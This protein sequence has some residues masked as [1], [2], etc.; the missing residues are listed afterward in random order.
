MLLEYHRANR[1]TELSPLCNSIIRQT[2]L[3]PYM[4]EQ[5]CL[6]EDKLLLNCFKVD[7]GYKEEVVLHREQ[8]LLLRKL[9]DGKDIAVSAPTSFGKSFVIDS[10]IK[11]KRPSNVMI[12]V[13]TIALTDETRRR[14]YKKFSND[15]KIITTIDTEPGE[16]NI[17]I[18]PQ[19]R[20]LSWVDRIESL[21]ILVIDE[22][23]KASSQLTNDERVPS[24]VKAIIK[25]GSKAKQRYFLAPNISHLDDNPFTKGM[26]FLKLDFNTVFLKKVDY[27]KNIGK[28]EKKKGE[29]LLELNKKLQGKTLIF[30]GTHSQVEKV[31]TLLSANTEEIDSHLLS[32]FGEWL[33][34]NYEYNWKLPIL[35]RRG[36][37][38]HTGQ[39]HRSLSQIQVKLFEEETGLSRL[40]STSSII[41]GV[42]TSAENVIVWTTS[43]RGFSLDCFSYK[44]VIGRAGR[45]FRHFVGNI[46]VLQQAPAETPI[47]LTIE[48][49]E[50]VAGE[51]DHEKYSGYLTEDQIHAIKQQEAEMSFFLGAELYSRIKTG[52]G[53]QTSNTSSMKSIAVDMKEAPHRWERLVQLSYPPEYWDNALYKLLYLKP[54][55]WETSYSKFVAFIKIL[56]G[57]WQKT[58]PE[59]LYELEQYDLGIDDFF[60]LERI[61][62]FKLGAL[63]HDVDLLQK[64]ILPNASFDVSPFA[65]QVSHAFLPATVYEL[66]EYGLPRMISRKIHNAG[67][68]DFEN[69][70]LTFEES[71]SILKDLGPE[72]IKSIDTIDTFDCYLIDFFFD[73]LNAR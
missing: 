72:I 59:L 60:K 67:M 30:A 45:M 51:I 26:E 27:S 13:P 14:I 36:I 22:F 68:I 32:S 16:R 61:V 42:N 40:V 54:G 66:E 9:L 57:N 69:P 19:E 55:W 15:Y 28:D 38:I 6:F 17:F 5:T 46:H 29:K 4:E 49:P 23:Y 50:Q 64:S 1:I 39:L 48:L 20:A 58:I 18:F 7:A 25:I 41:E 56:S 21:D 33:G 44:N 35:A 52:E 62:T 73:G 2:G 71:L 3:Y 11:L 12:I 31:S 65:Y 53:F 10:F 24:L 43:T 63:L 47:S 37:G 70:Q 34:K 8:Y